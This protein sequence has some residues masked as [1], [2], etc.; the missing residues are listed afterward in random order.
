VNA[1]R[2]NLDQ[3]GQYSIYLL[4]EWKGESYYS[5]FTYG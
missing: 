2:S 1:P 5:L 4:K 3:T